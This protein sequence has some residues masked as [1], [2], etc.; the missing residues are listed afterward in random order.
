MQFSEAREFAMRRAQI[1]GKVPLTCIEPVN[2]VIEGHLTIV[3][4]LEISWVT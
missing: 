3:L 4:I 1:Y 2:Q